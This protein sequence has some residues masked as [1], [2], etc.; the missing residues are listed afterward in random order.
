M[1]IESLAFN[2]FLF[3]SIHATTQDHSSTS[4][5]LLL[6]FQIQ[7]AYSSAQKNEIWRNF[8]MI[9]ITGGAGFIGLHTAR[10]LLEKGHDVI[11]VDRQP[12]R[13]PDF[14]VPH[15]D[16]RVK[17]YEG[18]ILNLP[19]LYEIIREH[20][21]ESIIHAAVIIA[22]GDH[23]YEALKVNLQGTVDIME[24]ARIFGLRR[25]TYLSSI[26]VYLP[27]KDV[28]HLHENMDL[29][30]LSSDPISMAKK[31]GEQICLLYENEYRLSCPIIRMPLVWGPLYRGERS[32][33]ANMIKN[34]LSSKPSEFSHIY[35]KAKNV[36]LYV[37]DAAKAIGLVHLTPSLKHRIYNVS[38]GGVHSLM[39]FAME[40]RK[41]VPE[42]TIQLGER[43]PDEDRK[44]M[45]EKDLPPM[46]IER[47]KDELGFKPDYDLNRGVAAY[48]DW[49]RHE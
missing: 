39:D 5:R 9:L 17:S 32:P 3:A 47:I 46:S 26:A 8:L 24:A 33:L 31:A 22:A 29:P 38:D 7:F 13:V 14:L 27:L 36:Y 4:R 41:L 23:F 11:L 48:M 45:I 10:A 25:V 37:E 28:P 34:V 44:S 6:A 1:A 49:A 18:D 35:G 21:V 42:A 2:N 30:P 43:E 40:I 20:R 16:T 12:L 19:F 15:M